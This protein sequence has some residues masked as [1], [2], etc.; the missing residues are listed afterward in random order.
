MQ[1]EEKIVSYL[2]TNT[3]STLNNLTGKTKNV[4]FVC[5]G[6]GYLSKYF[7]R[8]F[9]ELNPE[10]NYIIAPQAPSKYY[11]KDDFKHVGASW[12]TKE[13]TIRETENVLNYLNTVFHEEN[14]PDNVNFIA[15]GFSQG[16]SVLT[17]WISRFK[18]KCNC[19]VLY[20]GSIPNE[21]TKEDFNDFRNCNTLVKYIYGDKDPYINEKR[22]AAELKKAKLLFENNIEVIKFDGVHEVKKEIISTIT[23]TK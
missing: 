18:I 13:N 23:D 4:W 6:M 16:V 22:I 15:L 2:H 3:Y 12:L 19:L 7:I 1:N 21:L 14:I 11:Q 9:N 10:E 20:A 5:H 8:H 17:R